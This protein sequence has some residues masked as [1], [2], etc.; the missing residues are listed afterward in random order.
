MTVPRFV[1]FL[2]AGGLAA[3]ANFGS[4]ILLSEVM[5][6]VP[7]IIIAYSIGMT[8]AFILNRLFVFDD[9]ANNM[10]EQIVWFTLVNI[11]AVLQT[12]LISLLFARIVFPWMGF[13]WHVETVAHGIGVAVPVVTSYYG[14]R[15]LTFRGRQ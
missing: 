5:P 4:R 13:D 15:K 12:V 9:A 7:A 3:A 14:H 11:A 2:A 8:T 10:R 6:Y 1:R